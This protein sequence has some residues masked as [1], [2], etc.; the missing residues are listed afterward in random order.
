M[1]STRRALSAIALLAALSGIAACG[2]ED[3]GAEGAT[4]GSDSSASPS[5]TASGA[6]ASGGTA[7]DGPTDDV[8][9]DGQGGDCGKPP[10]LPAGHTR[11]KITLMRDAAGFEAAVAKPHCT[12]ND[13]IYGADETDPTKHYVLPESVDA[14][15][16]LMDGPGQWKKVDHE[17]LALH[18]DRCHAM[19]AGATD[20]PKVEPPFGCFG[21]VYEITL[22]G[23]GE[24]KTIKEIWSV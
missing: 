23:K 12:P 10:V 20:Y 13:W 14:R 6:P 19:E 17:Q 8:D 11:V 21:N 3:T 18:I 1:T 24:V 7:G 2:P 9:D 4:G 16:A 5:A 22:D 15:L